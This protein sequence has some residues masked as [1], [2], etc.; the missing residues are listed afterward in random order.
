MYKDLAERMNQMDPAGS[1]DDNVDDA[2]Q[3]FAGIE[4]VT[5]A[6]YFSSADFNGSSMP[7]LA[8]HIRSALS[9]PCS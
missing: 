8:T 5:A 9:K 6:G 1:N 2:A 3:L 7:E 4:N